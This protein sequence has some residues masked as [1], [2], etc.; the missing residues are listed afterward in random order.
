[1]T[2]SGDIS[3]GVQE[4]FFDT[5]FPKLLPMAYTLLMLYFLKKKQ[6]SPVILIVAT[7]AISI[8]CSAIGLL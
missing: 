4:A 7:I 6:V 1:I 2:V 5:I 8:I 3:V